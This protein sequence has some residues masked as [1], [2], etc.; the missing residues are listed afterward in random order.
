MRNA[1]V[2]IFPGINPP[3]TD[4][5]AVRDGRRARVFYYDV[6]LSTAR[7]IAAGT[8]L[9]LTIAGNSFFCDQS[10]NQGAATVYF[11]DFTLTPTDAPP[12]YCG[13]GFVGTVPF[14]TLLI[15]NTAQAGKRFRFF[16]GVDVDFKPSLSGSIALTGTINAAPYGMSYGASYKST[17]ALVANTGDVVFSPGA[18]VNG[19]VIW[20]AGFL[21]QET[22]AAGISLVAKASAPASIVDGD[23][24]LQTQNFTN[25]ASNFECGAL[26]NPVFVAAG[27]GAY[28][29]AAAASNTAALRSA[30]YTLL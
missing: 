20:A 5:P 22:V 11:Q 19:A 9:I 16:Y 25:A 15:E 18:N 24:L 6:D 13:P 8:A 23:V 3:S 26:P 4:F 30:L 12:I 21:H 10:P 29:I 7:S 2:P 27:K 1:D 28:F 14:T 17:S